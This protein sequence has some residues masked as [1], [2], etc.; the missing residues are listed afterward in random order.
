MASGLIRLARS[1]ELNLTYGEPDR[2]YEP[3]VNCKVLFLGD[4]LRPLLHAYEEAAQQISET[5]DPASLSETLQRSPCITEFYD[6]RRMGAQV[7]IALRDSVFRQAGPLS[8]DQFRITVSRGPMRLSR[9][10]P[11]SRFRALGALLPLLEGDHS[12][13]EIRARLKAVL[14]AEEAAWAVDVLAALAAGGFL[15]PAAGIKF[16]GRPGSRPRV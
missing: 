3:Q 15:E 1:A 5:E 11:C 10:A 4:R 12:E 13:T 2:L 16:F 14:S 7:S 8:D 6:V 9:P